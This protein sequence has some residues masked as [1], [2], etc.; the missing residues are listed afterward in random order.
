MRQISFRGLYED[1][2]DK[3]FLKKG[4]DKR[5][6]W[7]VP[8]FHDKESFGGLCSYV[9]AMMR[10]VAPKELEKWNRKQFIESMK[11]HYLGWSEL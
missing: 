7:S 1:K 2:F 6:F 9:P 11:V 4:E 5:G 8:S 10:I 3:V